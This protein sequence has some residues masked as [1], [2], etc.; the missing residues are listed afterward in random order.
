MV[1]T[2]LAGHKDIIINAEGRFGFGAGSSEENRDFRVGTF[3]NPP[4]TV[5]NKL[6]FDQF[7]KEYMEISG[8][9]YAM[10]REIANRHNYR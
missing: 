3:N 9:L 10:A 4:F 2:Y 1:H 5:V 7:N 6:G 8:P